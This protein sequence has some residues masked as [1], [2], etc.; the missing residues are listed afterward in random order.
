MVDDTSKDWR[1]STPP[2]PSKATTSPIFD[3]R[4]GSSDRK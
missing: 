3:E 1:C 2:C 4:W